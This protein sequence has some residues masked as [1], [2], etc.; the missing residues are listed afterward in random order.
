[1]FWQKKKKKK[2]TKRIFFL[3]DVC[4]FSVCVFCVTW[5]SPFD[6]GQGQNICL[7]IYLITR[8][9]DALLLLLLRL[10]LATKSQSVDL[11]TFHQSIANAC[12]GCVRIFKQKQ[13]KKR[14]KKQMTIVNYTNRLGHTVQ[15]LLPL[16]MSAMGNRAHRA[17]TVESLE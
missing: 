17:D 7:I 8:Q 9:H 15:P 3:S 1:M 11:A 10:H 2:L 6:K 4:I 13:Q 12:Q 5:P 16:W 14:R